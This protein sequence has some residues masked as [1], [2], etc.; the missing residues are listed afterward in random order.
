VT[1]TMPPPSPK[2]WRPDHTHTGR[3]GARPAPPAEEW[4]TC[5]TCWGQQRIWANGSHGPGFYP[6]ATC[7][8]TGTEWR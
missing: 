8:G 7:L 1:V 5:R 6:C 3:C 4:R 2:G